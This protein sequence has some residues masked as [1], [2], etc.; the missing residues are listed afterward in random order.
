LHAGLEAGLNL[1][2]FFLA[3]VSAPAQALVPAAEI[4]ASSSGKKEKLCG[5]LN[6]VAVKC[7]TGENS[8]KRCHIDRLQVVCPYPTTG[9][10][11]CTKQKACAE[12]TVFSC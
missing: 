8:C 10:V 5:L 9:S 12:A 1:Y 6:F 7:P 4:E 2:C 11:D 3:P